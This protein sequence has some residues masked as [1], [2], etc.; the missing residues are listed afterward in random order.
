MSSVFG[1]GLTGLNAAQANL[2]TI[3][4]NIANATT[5]GYH[6]QRVELQASF[7]QNSTEGFL[8][9]GVEVRTV[10]RIYSE[11]LDSQVAT[12][13]GR[14]SYLTSYRDLVSQIDNLLAD[15]NAGLTPAIGEFFTGLQEVGAD[16]ESPVTRQGLLSAAATLVGRFQS[17][18]TR[19]SG[20]V[21]GANRQVQALV[22]SINGLATEIASLNRSIV[23]AE[24]GSAGQPANDLYD[25][26]DALVGQLNA[27]T[28]ATTVLQSDGTVNVMI[29]NGQNLVVGEQALTLAAIPS[30][31]DVRRYEIGYQT[32]GVTSIIT[33][34]LN[35]GELGAMLAFQR[36]TLDTTLNS[37][38]RIATTI[39]YTFN[40]QHRLGQDLNG[41][42]GQDFFVVPSPEVLTRTNNAG[43]GLVTATLVDPGNLTTSDYRVI[44]NPPGY[45]VTRLSDNTSTTYATL[46]QTI[47]GVEIALASGT[48]VA[49]DS[50]LVRPTRGGARGIE[51]AITEGAAIAAASPIRAQAAQA[52]TGAAVAT[53]GV[54]NGPPPVNVNL[55]QPV[56]ITFTSANTFDVTGTGT[57]NPTGVA[58]TSGSTI[59]YNGWSIT[60]SGV[61]RAGDVFTVTQNTG[62]VSDNRNANLL[63]TLQS[64][65]TIG[66]GAATY[67]S[68]YSQSVANVGAKTRELT[69][70]SAAQQTLVDQTNAAQQSMSG[71]NLDEEA[72]NLI[73]YQQMYQAAG[74][75]IEIAS[76]LFESLLAI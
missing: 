71:V 18:E 39:A 75:M 33:S 63:A 51:V 9:T 76:R 21:E 62:G 17:L 36:E 30:P 47:D 11:F 38:G 59:T 24:A 2:A 74:K 73:R 26:R 3:G 54:V 40:Q 19:I 13:Q 8:G 46:P 34:S 6:R 68:A 56:S 1:I 69:V 50:F 42:P 65:K 22:T 52:N 14:L 35:A 57:G 15:P 7:P 67:Q 32:G 5:P 28:G 29:G 49:G 31:E 61:P 44:Y 58:Y 53:A 41:A 70:A 66:S 45:T 27:L 60:I 43:T 4:H 55:T 37:L 12:A 10:K 48:P 20:M 72:A 23:R 25:K 64:A 16:P